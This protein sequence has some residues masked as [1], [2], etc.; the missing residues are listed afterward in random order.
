VSA[1]NAT[2]RL[3]SASPKKKNEQEENLLGERS[4]ERKV[5]KIREKEKERERDGER[6]R[7]R[8]EEEEREREREREKW[9]ETEK[10]RERFAT[11]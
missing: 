5:E 7:K 11:K 2:S 9:R 6:Q 3:S 1:S 8:E 4:K 10:E